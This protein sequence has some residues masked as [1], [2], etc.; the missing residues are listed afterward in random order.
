MSYSIENKVGREKS[1][2]LKEYNHK[3]AFCVHYSIPLP[4]LRYDTMPDPYEVITI[5]VNAF[6]FIFVWLFL[7]MGARHKTAQDT[8]E[9][10]KL[11][12]SLSFLVRFCEI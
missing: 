7:W 8:D 3:H 5:K 4:Q 6:S 9:L 12:F 11:S 10:V 1:E 2:K